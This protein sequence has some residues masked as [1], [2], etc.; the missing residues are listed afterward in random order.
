MGT[1]T[2]TLALAIGILALCG[3]A[4]LAATSLANNSQRL[5]SPLSYPGAPKPPNDDP[6]SPYAMNYMDE[7]AQTLGVRNGHMDVFSSRPV[8]N[9]PLV[10]SGGLGGDG[11]MLKL[12]WRPGL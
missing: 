7:A 11:A 2:R 9:N 4:G 8:A 12:Q 6:K 10:V 1:A 5:G 3:T